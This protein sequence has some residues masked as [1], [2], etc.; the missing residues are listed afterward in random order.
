MGMSEK[1]TDSTLDPVVIADQD[2]RK[3]LIQG[4]T[5][6]AMFML[7]SGGN[8]CSWNSGAEALI[9]YSAGEILGCHLR[10]FYPPQSVERA[11]PEE[12]LKQCAS[13]GEMRAEGWHKR[14]HAPVFWAEMLLMA[15][16]DPKE[17]LRGFAC[18]ITDYTER[19]R[20]DDLLAQHLALAFASK[21]DIRHF[22][23]AIGTA[24]CELV[25]HDHASLTVRDEGSSGLRLL[26]LDS[27]R[28]GEDSADP[29]ALLP[30]EGSPQEWVFASGRSLVLDRLDDG[31]FL[32]A[33]LGDMAGA[34]MK[35]A[36]FVPIP[37]ARDMFG[38]LNL[39]RRSGDSFSARDVRLLTQIAARLGP[40]LDNGLPFREFSGL[41]TKAAR[42]KIQPQSHFPAEYGFEDIVGESSIMKRILG[43]AE[44]VAETDATVLILGETGVGKALVARAIHDL[45]PRR[46]HAFVKFNC[47][48]IPTGLLESE[49]FGHEK[50]AFTGANAQRLGRLDLAHRGTLFLDEVGDIPLEL[51][52]KLLRALQEKE[53]ERLGST[54][55]IP[56]DTRLIAA[57]NR[58]LAQMV[59]DGQFR[60]DLY[61]RLK[62]FPIMVPPLREHRED[63]PLLARYFVQKH[64]FRMN[65]RIETIP[66]EAMEALVQWDWPGNVRELG[67][68]L[69][70]AVILTRGPI[71]HVPLGELKT[72]SQ[73]E[74]LPSASLEQIERDYIMRVLRET[75]GVVGGPRGAAARLGLNRS[76]LNSRMRKLRIVRNAL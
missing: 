28:K 47:A 57:T 12:H 50:G 23:A 27:A 6:R 40:A 8:V 34:G 59:R 14:K 30:A 46:G 67:N 33:A 74:S 49:L 39:A 55:T 13:H 10:C 11:L 18:F 61:Y 7:D 51:Q 64:A 29:E 63:I 75:R 70:R 4:T 71:L 21:L 32:H 73:P 35:I 5:D 36:C 25:P 66:P 3:L 54:L 69:E 1:L 68:F 26:P 72:P 16:R 37:G 15:L 62:V 42:E 43:Q 22:L 31:R 41:T 2:Y 60:S 45:S 19:K 17:R 38:T 48:A 65:K 58:N 9:G 44:T 76:T 56:I 52:P 20:A 24:V 53:F